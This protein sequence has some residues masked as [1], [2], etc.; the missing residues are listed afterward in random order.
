[1]TVASPIDI[2]YVALIRDRTVLLQRRHNTGFMDGYFSCAAA[3]HV[4]PA[5]SPI[6]AACREATEEL[7]I[8]IAPSDLR[9]LAV[10]DRR[11]EPAAPAPS[12]R[13][14]FFLCRTWG[15]A[16]GIA[17]PQ[18]CAELRWFSFDDLPSALVPHEAPILAGLAELDGP[19]H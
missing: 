12:H 2:V 9:P 15:G 14:H 1:M 4:E 19:L 11:Q 13:D 17:E 8:L 10:R 6:A 3:G 7:G 5:E 16:P 18:K